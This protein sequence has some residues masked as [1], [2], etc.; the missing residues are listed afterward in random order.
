MECW[1]DRKQEDKSRRIKNSLR[2]SYE[3]ELKLAIREETEVTHRDWNKRSSCHF[4]CLPGL[5][6]AV[7]HPLAGWGGPYPG[8]QWWGSRL[9]AASGPCGITPPVLIQEP[10]G[11][12]AWAV[13]HFSF[14]DFTINYFLAAFQDM[15]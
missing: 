2:G 5:Q 13:S 8:P 6:S 15:F 12:H 10:L 7:W 9:V 3:P 4:S 11:A 1:N 14:L